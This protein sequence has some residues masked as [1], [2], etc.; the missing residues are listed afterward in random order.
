MAIKYTID[1]ILKNENL[2][3]SDN[4]KYKDKPVI[5][6]KHLYRLWDCGLYVI[7]LFGRLQLHSPC[8]VQFDSKTKKVE[9]VRLDESEFNLWKRIIDLVCG[10][11]NDDNMATTEK[12]NTDDTNY[13]EDN[14][15]AQFI[16][17]EPNIYQQENKPLTRGFKIKVT[18]KGKLY[19]KFADTIRQAHNWR[20][21]IK[22]LG[23]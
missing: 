17:I 13:Y 9:Y 1:D 14:K 5:K 18:H 3:V 2:D 11:K 22:N 15:T 7:G 23:K 16:R 19:I 4:F 6:A 10:I 21:V 20:K 12:N 8:L